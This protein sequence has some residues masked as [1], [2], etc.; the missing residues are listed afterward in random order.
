MLVVSATTAIDPLRKLI[1]FTSIN[2]LTSLPVATYCYPNYQSLLSFQA[3]W[4]PCVRMEMAHSLP[5]V[6]SLQPEAQHNTLWGSQY[7]AGPEAEIYIMLEYNWIR[8]ERCAKILATILKQNGIQKQ[9]RG[10]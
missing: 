8:F 9:L 1:T 10:S 7:G 3:L 4:N 5:R 2:K 6:I